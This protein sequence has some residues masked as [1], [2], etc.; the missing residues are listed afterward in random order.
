MLNEI[1]IQKAR[2]ESLIIFFSSIFI[3]LVTQF[4]IIDET[5]DAVLLFM[6]IPLLIGILIL[7]KDL[8]NFGFKFGNLKIGLIAGLFLSLA[9]IILVYLAVR[10]SAHLNMYY[11]GRKLYFKIVLETII[12]MFSWEFFLRGFLLFGLRDNIGPLRANIVQTLLFFIAHWNKVPLEFYSTLITGILFGYIAL[13]SRS[14]WPIAFI[15][16]V[17]YIS[18]VFF[19]IKI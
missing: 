4:R 5:F 1:L 6:F 2:D 11:S 10:Y 17:I 19:T 18:V 9:S 3:L 12:Y 15:H 14:F 16:A 13:K 8:K 7:K